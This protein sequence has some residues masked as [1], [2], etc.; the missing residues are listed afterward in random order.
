MFSLLNGHI[1][2]NFLMTPGIASRT[3]S[4]SSLVFHLPRVNCTALCASSVGM[5]H[6]SSTCDGRRLFDVHGELDETELPI[7]SRLSSIASPSTNLNL[8][9]ALFGGLLAGGPFRCEASTRS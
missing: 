9:L 6:A 4:I 7:M 2:L 5:P 3:S 8:K 1:A